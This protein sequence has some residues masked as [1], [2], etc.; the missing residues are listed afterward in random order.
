M[1]NKLAVIINSLKVPK[2]KKILL[3]EM[4]FLVPSYSCLQNPWLWGYRPQIPLLSVLYP[5]LNL[6]NPP[7]RTKF[8]G[9]P[10]LLGMFYLHWYECLS[11]GLCSLP[12]TFLL[13]TLIDGGRDRWR[14][15]DTSDALRRI[16]QVLC[17]DKRTSVIEAV[18]IKLEK[19]QCDDDV[20][21]WPVYGVDLT[22]EC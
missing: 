12:V 10:L 11:I 18:V 7:L 19:W 6:L 20:S 15:K 2:I 4:K 9:T 17:G 21:I 1:T 13:W 8:L 3:Y 5:Q 14:D 22:L 16:L